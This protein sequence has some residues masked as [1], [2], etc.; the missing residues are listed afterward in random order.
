M[1]RL[2]AIG[3]IHAHAGA[4]PVLRQVFTRA[5]EEADLLLIAGDLTEIGL[6][7]QAEFPGDL[8]AE[9]EVPTYAVLGNHDF[10]H[11]QQVAIRQILERH[12]VCI[13]DGDGVIVEQGGVRIGIAGAVG[14]GGGFRPF[15]LTPFGEPEWKHFYGKIVEETRKLDRAFAAISGADYLIGLMHYGPTPDTM[16]DEPADIH[17]FLGSSELGDALERFKAF[18]GIHGH[19]H[20][21]RLEGC[22]A[23]G[24]PVFNVAMPIIDCPVVWELRPPSE[25]EGHPPP[26][27]P[28][29]LSSVGGEL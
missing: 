7:E 14:F 28:R 25:Y 10:H 4:E 23:N 19:A 15:N 17:P 27:N 18:M 22:T 9:F 12:G 26:V 8:L 6:Q 3:D 20:R 13:L 29:L 24:I 5:R 1:V 16:G 21:G 11:D 2:A